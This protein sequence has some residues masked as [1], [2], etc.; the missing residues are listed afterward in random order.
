MCDDYVILF[1]RSTR[2]SRYLESPFSSYLF[3]LRTRAVVRRNDYVSD[4][5]VLN[6]VTVPY[7]QLRNFFNQHLGCRIAIST[8]SYGNLTYEVIYI[9]HNPINHRAHS[10]DSIII[11]NYA[12]STIR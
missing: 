2:E 10:H 3:L 5:Y 7:P 11:S 9:N 4:I 12:S 8:G 6:N 1:N